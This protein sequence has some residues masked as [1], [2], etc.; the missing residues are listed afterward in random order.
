MPPA[1]IFQNNKRVLSCLIAEFWLQF[2]ISVAW[3]FFRSWTASGDHLSTFVVNFS[4]AFFFTSWMFGQDGFKYA[5]KT[6]SENFV[7]VKIPTDF[8]GYD[9]EAPEK[10][11]SG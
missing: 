1:T 9:P 8:P 2:V 4:A 10:V 5:I 6:E 11:F 7:D 3:A